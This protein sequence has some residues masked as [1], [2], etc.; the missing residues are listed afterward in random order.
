MVRW[1]FSDG[2][3]GTKKRVSKF[4]QATV[5]L[6]FH[7]KTEDQPIEDS[8][9]P[10]CAGRYIS[11]AEL[12]KKTWDID[13]FKCQKCNGPT[14]IGKFISDPEAILKVMTQAG[15]SARPPPDV[16]VTVVIYEQ[17]DDL[18]PFPN[19]DAFDS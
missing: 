12:L 15:L 5:G 1:H 6:L 17:T 10:E 16:K 13:I 2:V 11:W 14:R 18:D 8:N 19:D 3:R 9:K 7:T 4:S